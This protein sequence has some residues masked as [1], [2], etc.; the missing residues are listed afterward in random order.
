[1]I[2][3]KLIKVNTRQLLV[4]LYLLLAGTIAFGQS[5]KPNIIYILSDD[6]AWNDYGFMGA[7]PY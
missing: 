6:Q 7:S 4:L 5:S 2:Y 1:M 3:L